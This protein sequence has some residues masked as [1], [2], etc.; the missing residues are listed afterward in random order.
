MKLRLG[1]NVSVVKLFIEFLFPFDIE[2]S[3][4]YLVVERTLH[5]SYTCEPN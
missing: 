1:V 4:N 2:R 5:K 3:N